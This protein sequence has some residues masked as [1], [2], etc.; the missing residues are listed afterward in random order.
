MHL[1]ETIATLNERLKE[2][3]GI[4]TESTDPIFRVVWSDAQYENRLTDRTPT[5]IQLLTPQ[6]TKLPKYQWVKA[7]YILERLVIVPEL[8]QIE[9]AGLQKSYEPLWVFENKK[10][11]AV[12]PVWEAI[13]MIIDTMYA[14]LGKSSLAKYVDEE[15]KNPIEAREKRIAKIEEELFGDESFLLGRTITGEAVAMPTNYDEVK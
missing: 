1:P 10:G 7:K 11:E 12:P 8:Q 15:A 9:L 5:G 13:K 6:V 14:A 4:D 3:F 2:Y